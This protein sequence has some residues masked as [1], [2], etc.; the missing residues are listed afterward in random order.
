MP[1]TPNFSMQA[2]KH[3]YRELG[4]RLWGPYGFYDAFNLGANWY[5]N[6]YLAIDQGPI[7][8]M[9]ENHR[10]GL[11]WNLFMQ[12]PEIPQALSAVGF[13]EDDTV[14]SDLSEPSPLVTQVKFSPNPATEVIRMQLTMDAPEQ[15]Q[16]QLTDIQGRIVKTLLPAGQLAAGEHHWTFS[17]GSLAPGYYGLLFTTTQHSWVEPLLVSQ[18]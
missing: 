3:F 10:S 18:P 9:I 17:L 1:Y 13:V 7:I 12:N 8:C 11:L 4:Q 2:L 16:I 14:I 5:A 15:L 6:S